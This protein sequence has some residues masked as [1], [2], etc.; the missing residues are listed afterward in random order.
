M[1]EAF[2][3]SAREPASIQRPTVEVEAPGMV[4]ETTERPFER[5]EVLV[6]GSADLTGVASARARVCY[7]HQ[8]S[9][10][11]LSRRPASPFP[12]PTIASLSGGLL[13]C[14]SSCNTEPRFGQ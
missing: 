5:V 13:A 4:S 11:M 14:P 12:P 8:H 7:Q 6:M 10:S 1:P 9:Q 3:A 2:E